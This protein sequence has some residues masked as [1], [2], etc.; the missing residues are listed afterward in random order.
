MLDRRIHLIA[1]SFAL[2]LSAGCSSVTPLQDA[3]G[4]EPGGPSSDTQGG[5]GGDPDGGAVGPADVG[6]GTPVDVGAGDV[7][8]SASVD[9]APDSGHG[10]DAAVDDA[11]GGDPDV[12]AGDA[13]APGDTGGECPPGAGGAPLGERACVLRFASPLPPGTV[14]ASV[15]SELNEW[16]ASGDWP[17]NDDDGDGVW[18][19][20][21]D[22][23]SMNPG[24]YGYKLYVDDANW[25]LDPATP[26]RKVVSTENNSKLYVPDCALPELVVE[27][28][29]ID[30]AAGAVHAVV[31]VADGTGGALL[32]ESAIASLGGAALP[33]AWD[34]ASERFTVAATGLPA[35]KHTLR[36]RVAN[37]AGDAA[38]VTV[39]VWIE[40]QA[41]SWR[42]AVLYFAFVDRFD[43]GDP[44][45]DG[46]EACI[47]AD[48]PAR[49]MGG[50]WKGLLARIEGGW[51]DALGVNALWLTA[52][53]DNPSGCFSGDLPGKTYTAYHGYFPVSLT[54]PEEHFGTMEDLK[55]VVEA[56]H[57]RGIRVLVDLVANHVHEQHPA[58]KAHP[59]WFNPYY[60]CGFEEKPVECWFQPYL[61]DLDYTKDEAVEAFTDMAVWWVR[62]ADIDGFR[63]DAVKHVH[64]N[65]LRTLR[66]K[67]DRIG[68]PAGVD[69]YLVGETF[70]GD[71]GGGTGP[72]EGTIKAYVGSELLHGQ[73]DFPLY[74]R[75]VQAFARGEATLAS[76]GQLL[77][78]SA[79]TYGPEAIMATFLGNHDVPRFISHAAG[80]IADVWGNGSKEQGYDSPPGTPGDAAPYERLRMAWTFLLTT[81]G[82]PLIYYGDEIGLPGAGDPDNRRMM[83]FDGLSAEQQAT[84]AHIGKVAAARAAHPALR[85]GTTQVLSG[86]D[87]TLVLLRTSGAD[88]V[89]VA[90][91][92]GAGQASVDGPSEGTWVDVLSDQTYDASGGSV[93]LPLGARSSAVLVRQ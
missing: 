78:E 53:A 86:A 10:P 24:T 91:N 19:G 41:F 40:P 80:T 61:P 70:V 46:N 30:G 67:L 1:A 4:A 45:N 85:T 7:A 74:W 77:T 9:A 28:L 49:W 8:D 58:Y 81:N 37:E 34:P 63:V 23:S 82:V 38:P 6:G 60:Q 12:T 43:N 29:D 88:E 11:G 72:N 76:L 50:D 65:F 83:Q 42:D 18:T 25:I 22:A 69:L 87:D 71:W 56:A 32:P 47:D 62:E 54:D 84:I 14:S 55:A 48:D 92:R 44:S 51:F 3:Y 59:D 13:T 20:E 90:W 36:I 57:A 2:G 66:W 33:C 27:S 31:A 75:T 68:K 64:A 73:F 15:R 39:P 52:P 5:G 26:L 93:T 35:G 89:V 21:V 79:G 16:G 17:L